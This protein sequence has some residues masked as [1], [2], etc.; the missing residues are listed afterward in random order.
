MRLRI[1]LS[2]ENN[3]PT[4]I[5]FCGTINEE[6]EEFHSINTKLTDC[7]LCKEAGREAHEPKRLISGGSGRGIVPLTPDEFKHSLP[8]EQRKIYEQASKSEN[9][10][11]NIIGPKYD[12]N[13]GK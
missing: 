7:P 3:M 6:F 10:A 1:E 8:T 11:S 2:K 12:K 13:Y 5:Y 4:Y 9:F